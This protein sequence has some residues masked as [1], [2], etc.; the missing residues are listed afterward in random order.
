M[1]NRI[2]GRVLTR[3][4]ALFGMTLTCVACYGTAYQEWRYDFGVNGRVVDKEGNAI[5]G[6]EV[7]TDGEHTTTAPDGYFYV[8]GVGDFAIVQ[9]LDTD[10][11][12]NGGEFLP[13]TIEVGT[14][15]YA[16]IGDVVLTRVGEEENTNKNE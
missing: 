13:R 11:K 12:A 7:H 9:F 10:G 8:E 4:F 6:I 1:A 14:T 5:E 16:D 3:I 2:L 15:S